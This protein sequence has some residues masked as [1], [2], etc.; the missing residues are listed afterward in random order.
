MSELGFDS[1][2][3]E[4]KDWACNQEIVGKEGGWTGDQTRLWVGC[5]VGAMLEN[6]PEPCGLSA[7]GVL[8]LCFF[9]THPW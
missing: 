5:G 7:A 1:G 8:G 4:A 2:Q 3:S 6:G 9:H